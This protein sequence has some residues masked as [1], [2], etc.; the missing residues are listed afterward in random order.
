MKKYCLTYKA[1]RELGGIGGTIGLFL[2]AISI[3]LFAVMMMI[4]TVV[5]FQLQTIRDS[6]DIYCLYGATAVYIIAVPFV[7]LWIKDWTK[8]SVIEC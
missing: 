4:G 5:L 1:K 6:F 2:L 3:S 8:K 7:I